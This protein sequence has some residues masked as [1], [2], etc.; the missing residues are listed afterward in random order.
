MK[1]EYNEPHTTNL[2][3]PVEYNVIYTHHEDRQYLFV[4]ELH[5]RVFVSHSNQT[6]RNS[7][8]IWRNI[9]KIVILLFQIVY[10]EVK[11]Y[12]GSWT[13]RPQRKKP[14][15]NNIYLYRDLEHKKDVWINDENEMVELSEQ[16][17]YDIKPE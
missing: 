15:Q 5:S 6:W 3:S 10:E 11:W 2:H 14:T 17:F 8:G 1:W 13:P 7:M 9:G 16:P 12:I 4:L